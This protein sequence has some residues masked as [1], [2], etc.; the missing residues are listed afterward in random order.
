LAQWELAEQAQAERQPTKGTEQTAIDAVPDLERTVPGPGRRR[1][2]VAAGIVAVVVAVGLTVWLSRS[3]PTR[4]SS[5]TQVP[6]QP[7]GYSC[8]Y[9]TRDGRLYAGHSTTSD[10]VVALNAGS[11]DVV[12]VQCLLVHHHLDPGRIDGLYGEHT[13]QAV[14]QLQGAAGAVVDGVVGPQTWALLR[15]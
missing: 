14:Q 5:A 3:G 4:S 8:D 7:G 12:E 9:T 11:E 2:V 15:A 6:V 10:R 1:R 13:A